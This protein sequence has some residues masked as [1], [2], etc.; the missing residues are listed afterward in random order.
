MII[1]CNQNSSIGNRN[2]NIIILL[3]SR[4][5]K[6]IMKS[7]IPPFLVI[8]KSKIPST[9]IL[10]DASFRMTIKS[11][12]PPFA[13]YQKWFITQP[14]IPCSLPPPHHHWL[15]VSVCWHCQTC[16][17]VLYKQWAAIK[18]YVN[19]RVNYVHLICWCISNF[20]FFQFVCIQV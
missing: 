17:M 20:R 7:E 3:S 4:E 2:G 6:T 13:H 11:K 5:G 12:V 14:P 1:W 8:L 19:N 15:I 16:Q 9:Q 18:L 10:I